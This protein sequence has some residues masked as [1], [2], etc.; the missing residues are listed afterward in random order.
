MMRRLTTR[1]IVPLF[2]LQ[3]VCA[4]LLHASDTVPFRFDG[5]VILVE[6]ILNST[7]RVKLIVDTGASETV[8]TPRM[9]QAARIKPDRTVA[10][11]M[12]GLLR[13]ITV[14]DATV[15]TLPVCLIDPVQALPLRLDRGIDYHGI[16]GRTFLSNFVV[17]IDYVRRE[18][19]F[20]TA[21]EPAGTRADL[22]KKETGVPMVIRP[23]G[24]LQVP[25][26]VNSK[27][28][29]EFLL[30]TGAAETIVIPRRLRGVKLSGTPLAGYDGV[31]MVV[32][33]TVT[34]GK[35]T[36]SDVNMLAFY[37]AQIRGRKNLFDGI[38][39]STF[40]SNFI[41]TVDYPRRRLKLESSEPPSPEPLPI[42]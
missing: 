37:P 36:A 42:W 4:T 13:R 25:V 8:I 20:A 27:G 30:D 18:I 17:R 5:R 19:S 40:L 26:K 34:V 21:T 33:K 41:V 9:A 22:K 38:L 23:D 2:F 7:N 35:T 3:I 16:L 24:L 31:R 10:G 28:P 12:G 32:A 1:R 39:G 11:C 29:Y 15:T 6:G 14:G